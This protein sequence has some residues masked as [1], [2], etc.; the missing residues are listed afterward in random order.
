MQE[1]DIDYKGLM[2]QI[3]A[4]DMEGKIAFLAEELPH[5]FHEKYL[6]MTPRIVNLC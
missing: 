2:L 6:L 1:Y 5:D 3:S 4:S